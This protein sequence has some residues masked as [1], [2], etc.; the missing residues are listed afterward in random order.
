MDN[1]LKDIGNWYLQNI[2]ENIIRIFRAFA[3]AY[4]WLVHPYNEYNCKKL[5]YYSATQQIFQIF[6]KAKL[7]NGY[8]H[9]K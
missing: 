4:Y 1:P 5:G 8:Y 6:I 2:I 7:L 3:N 9:P